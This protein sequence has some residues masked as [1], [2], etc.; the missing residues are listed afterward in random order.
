[1]HSPTRSEEPMEVPA[2]PVSGTRRQR[3]NGTPL[4]A[5]PI[6]LTPRRGSMSTGVPRGLAQQ[7]SVRG[8]SIRVAATPEGKEDVDD[9]EGP[10][11]PTESLAMIW[12]TDIALQAMMDS[13][14]DFLSS[15]APRRVEG[16]LTAEPY[17]L[18]GLRNAAKTRSALDVNCRHLN[19]FSEE[20]YTNLVRYPQEMLPAMDIVLEEELKR[21]G[22]FSAKVRCRPY[23]LRKVHDVRNLDPENIDQL[24]CVT[25]MI[26]RTSAIVPELAQAYYRCCKCGGGV[27][28]LVDMGRIDEPTKCT[29]PGCNATGSMELVH[30]RGKYNDKQIVRLQEKP[31]AMKAGDTPS[32]TSLFAFEDL[33]D[34]VRPGDRVEITGIY[35]AIPRRVNPRTSTLYTVYRTYIDVIHYRVEGNSERDDITESV[36]LVDDAKGRDDDDD[37]PRT[38]VAFSRD[39][40]EAFHRFATENSGKS[41]YERLLECIAPAIYGHHDVKKGVLCM[42]FGGVARSRKLRDENEVFDEDDD[43][44]YPTHQ[45]S[46]RRERNNG[47]GSGAKPAAAIAKSRGDIN[48]LLCGDPGTAKSQLLGYVHKIAPRGVYTSGKGSSAVGL[49]ASVNRD[50]ETR[51]L[52]MESGA[53]VLSDLGICCIDEFDK[54]GDATRAVLHEA[55]EQQTI[56]LA[57]AGI[58]ATLNARASI[59]ASANPVHSRY[60]DKLSV[61][62]NIQ[63]PPTLLSRFDLIYLILDKPDREA[64]RRLAK[65]LVSLH[66]KEPNLP[67]ADIDEKFLRDYVKYA[68]ARI[69]PEISQDAR[70]QLIDSYVDLRAPGRDFHGRRQKSIPAT[71]RQLEGMIRISEALARMRLEESVAVPDVLEAVRLMKAATLEAAR[72]KTSNNID[73]YMIATGQSAQQRAH[74]EAMTSEIRKLVESHPRGDQIPVADLREQLQAQSDTQIDATL[75]LKAVKDLSDNDI[76]S[77]SVRNGV[78]VRR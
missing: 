78:I 68:R 11:V 19:Q 45:Q 61:V 59:L 46:R 75:F 24:V 56:S 12:G 58:V 2:T 47:E 1:M 15:F 37:D 55:M 13:F 71:P 50:P 34:F 36:A 32:T 14:A 27:D 64:D 22:L 76:I 8:P 20:L 41:T 7:S 4:S 49:T 5:T 18:R 29:V 17:Y 48:V 10:P 70:D 6:G 30:N 21:M 31:D 66:F 25:G 72:D 28:V 67:K 60:D 69:I 63:L 53:V 26:T 77:H 43:D 51:E 62:E 3:D 40:I 52:V 16:L 54:M 35:R 44:L 73:L 39:R 33:V 9:D 57:K 65:H 38:P 23:N 74:L 42:L